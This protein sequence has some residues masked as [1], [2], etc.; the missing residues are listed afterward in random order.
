MDSNTI[1]IYIDEVNMHQKIKLKDDDRIDSVL[2]FEE[3]M[4]VIANLKQ[5]NDKKSSGS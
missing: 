4:T 1:S 5:K 3:S 2:Y